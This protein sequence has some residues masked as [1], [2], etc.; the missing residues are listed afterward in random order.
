MITAF[1]LF[2]VDEIVDKV[3]FAARNKFA[4]TIEPLPEEK[5]LLN[6]KKTISTSVD[7]GVTIVPCRSCGREREFHSGEFDYDDNTDQYSLCKLCG[8]QTHRFFKY[9]PRGSS[10]SRRTEFT[11]TILIRFY[12]FLETMFGFLLYRYR[13]IFFGSIRKKG[14]FIVLRAKKRDCMYIV[15]GARIYSIKYFR[16]VVIDWVQDNMYL[17]FSPMNENR[18]DICLAIEI[19]DGF[20]FLEVIGA[21]GD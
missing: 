12:T 10:E 7:P 13:K 20:N 9:T 2:N 3:D 11:A 4:A 17:I 15:L 16:D 21:S 6:W 1:E 18:E 19:T 5:Y 14:F 8:K